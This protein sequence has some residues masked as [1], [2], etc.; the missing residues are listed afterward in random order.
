MAHNPLACTA[1]GG[2]DWATR[3]TGSHDD[4]VV[5]QVVDQVVANRFVAAVCKGQ[6]LFGAGLFAFEDEDGVLVLGEMAVKK[7]GEC[8]YRVENACIARL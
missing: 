4:D 3:T 8:A 1:Q 2:G 5:N 7:R 6:L